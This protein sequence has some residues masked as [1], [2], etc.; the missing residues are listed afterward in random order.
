MQE[1]THLPKDLLLLLLIINRL[2]FI[3]TELIKLTV[4]YI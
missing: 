1:L 3:I 2:L 4:S